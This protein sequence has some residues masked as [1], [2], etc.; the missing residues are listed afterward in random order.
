[1]VHWVYVD[2]DVCWLICISCKILRDASPRSLVILDGSYLVSG[3]L[4]EGLTPLSLTELGRGTSTYVSCVYTTQAGKCWSI[5]SGRHGD[6]G[7]KLSILVCF[8]FSYS[9]CQAV[10]HQL[11]THTLALAFFATH[12]G[13]LTDDFS[14]HPNIRNMHMSTLVDDEK[15]EVRVHIS[16]AILDLLNELS[17]T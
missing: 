9:S 8:A 5:H 13:S 3:L 1:M 2:V 12:Y 16:S 6:C 7:C 14:Y 10:L 4:V 17:L 15:R 11:S